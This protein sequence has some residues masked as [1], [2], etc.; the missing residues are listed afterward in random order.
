MF[1]TEL[2]LAGGHTETVLCKQETKRNKQKMRDLQCI[3][4]LIRTFTIQNQPIETLTSFQYLGR[5]ITSMDSDW[6]AARFNLNKARN[7]WMTISRVL[8]RASAFPRISA[9]FYKAT[10]Q[11]VLLYGSETWVI[12]DEILQLLTSF[13]HSIARRLTGRFPRPDPDTNEW[14][15]PS[16]QETLQQAGLFPMEEYLRW[17]RRYL[18]S[19]AQQLQLLQECHQAIQEE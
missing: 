2:Q 3:R 10:V 5:I 18:E 1:C 9:L 19:H 7:R 6:E 17:R 11:T 12:T 13:H 14:V 4:A 15:H 16:I 8:A